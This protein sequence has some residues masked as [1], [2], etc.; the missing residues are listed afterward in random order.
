VV[1]GSLDHLS[2][3][4]RLPE[5]APA[6]R[7]QRADIAIGVTPAHE[8]VLRWS[9]HLHARLLSPIPVQQ[10][11]LT[12]GVQS[13]RFAYFV[14]KTGLWVDHWVAADPPSLVRIDLNFHDSARHWPPLIIAPMQQRDA[15]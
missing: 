8:L 5:G 2:F 3:I 6:Q 15:Q 14:Q 13:V 4:A 1:N 11:T 9:P 10:I 12:S 7:T